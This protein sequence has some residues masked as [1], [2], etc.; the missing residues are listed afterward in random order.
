MSV[1]HEWLWEGG[2]TCNYIWLWIKRII[3]ARLAVEMKHINENTKFIMSVNQS[4]KRFPG[5]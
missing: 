5:Y 3:I 2:T 1:M 4:A